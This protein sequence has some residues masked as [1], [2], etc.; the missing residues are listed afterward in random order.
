MKEYLP[1][2]IDQKKLENTVHPLRIGD[3]AMIMDENSRRGDCMVIVYESFA[4]KRRP[5]G[6]HQD[7][8][9]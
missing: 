1:T 8:T 2:F 6:N 3:I 9:F 5:C 7:G 4:W